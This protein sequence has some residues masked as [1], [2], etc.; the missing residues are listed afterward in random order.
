MGWHHLAND[1]VCSIHRRQSFHPV[2]LM[3]P[4][5]AWNLPGIHYIRPVFDDWYYEYFQCASICAWAFPSNGGTLILCQKRLMFALWLLWLRPLS[6]CCHC[7]CCRCSPDLACG[8]L[9]RF[10]LRVCHCFHLGS[11]MS[12][13]FLQSQWELCLVKCSSMNPCA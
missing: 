3:A 10:Y 5:H 11:V 9:N 4:R 1:P 13:G 6:C 12:F 7:D 2:Q 8:K